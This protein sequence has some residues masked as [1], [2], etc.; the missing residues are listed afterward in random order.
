[1]LWKKYRKTTH[2]MSRFHRPLAWVPSLLTHRGNFSTVLSLKNTFSSIQANQY[3]GDLTC[4]QHFMEIG[5]PCRPATILDSQGRWKCHRCRV[6]YRYGRCEEAGCFT[7]D[8]EYFGQTGRE[9]S[10][11]KM[12]LL[13]KASSYI[14]DQIPPIFSITT[15]S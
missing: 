15:E 13:D 4:A 10:Q 8:G 2:Y 12:I 3:N 9:G 1:L 11:G 14:Q 7:A 6:L 5:M